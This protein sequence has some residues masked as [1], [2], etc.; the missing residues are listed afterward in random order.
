MAA[1]APRALVTLSLYAQY[2]ASKKSVDDRALNAGVLEWVIARLRRF[3]APA[4]VIEIGAGLGTMPAR[5][6]E[7]DGVRAA[8][9]TLLDADAHLLSEARE[10]LKAWSARTG[11]QTR[12]DGDDLVITSTN[13]SLTLTF[14]H[15]EIETFLT[16]GARR[17]TYDVLIGNAVLDLVD[18]PS[19]LP[20][21]LDLL[22]VGGAYWFSVNFD[23]ETI[24]LPEHPD[25]QH[26]MAVYH[27]SMDE[28]MRDG[29]PAGDSRTGRHLFGELPAAG[30]RIA[31]A[32]A[33]DWVVFGDNGQYRA[34]EADFLRHIL[35]TVDKELQ[36]HADVDRKALAA[37]IAAR[38][39]QLERGELVYIA[40]QLDFAG[41]IAGS[42][43]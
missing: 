11:R 15:R 26:F 20:Q 19:T 24:F 8:N 42:E 25:D 18:V 28:R 27:R 13:T 39:G 40:H 9:Y 31:R 5:L 37:W 1:L 7:L 6:L 16:D 2:L 36:R 38:S 3:E 17:G 22:A 41:T 33:S 21:L 30:A 35:R 34:Q 29:H 43:R 14:L 12:R 4:R 23:G 10:W 32:G